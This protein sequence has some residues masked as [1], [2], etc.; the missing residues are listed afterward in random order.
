MRNGHDIDRARSALQHLDPN[1]P[2]DQWVKTGM[3]A[4]A[5]GLSFDDFDQWSA[6]AGNYNAQACRA[7]WRSFKTAPGGVGAGALFG[8]A[9]DHGWTE[10]GKASIDVSGLL[11]SQARRIEDELLRRSMRIVRRWEQDA[12]WFTFY[13]RNE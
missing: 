9:R 11:R 8:M 2:R 10:K 4:H 13:G 6:T 5:A 1:C 3:A 12:V 7:T